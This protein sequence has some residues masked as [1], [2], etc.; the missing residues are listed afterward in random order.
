MIKTN[1]ELFVMLTSSLGLQLWF[2][3]SS[4]LTCILIS[5]L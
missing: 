1:L 5:W 4:I 3:L 2:F